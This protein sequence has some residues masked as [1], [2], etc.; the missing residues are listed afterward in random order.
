MVDRE[1]LMI[2]TMNPLNWCFVVLFDLP[3]QHRCPSE[4]NR[5]A[6]H[7]PLMVAMMNPL[8]CGFVRHPDQQPPD[9]GR[10]RSSPISRLSSNDEGFHEGFHEPHPSSWSTWTPSRSTSFELDDRPSVLHLAGRGK[11]TRRR[12]DDSNL[13]D[14]NS[15][16]FRRR[17]AIDPVRNGGIDRGGRRAGDR[18]QSRSIS[19]PAECLRAGRLHGRSSGRGASGLGG[20]RWPNCAARGASSCSAR[21]WQDTHSPAGA[22]S[23]DRVSRGIS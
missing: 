2:G 5:G 6:H 8:T 10:W 19:Q 4:Q 21:R 16:A 1:P 17:T 12:D 22:R 3:A 9:L 13:T 18:A 20:H 14:V 11:W 15:Q 23:I 7:E